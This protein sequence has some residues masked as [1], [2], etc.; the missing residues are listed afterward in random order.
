MEKTK[1]IAEL[2]ERVAGIE[3]LADEPDF[4]SSEETIVRYLK[5]RDW[6]VND[7]EKMLK[8]SIE[9][10]RK[11]K[12]LQQDCKWCHERPGCHS[13]RQVGFDEAGRPVVYS[14]FAQASLRHNSVEDT[15]C[16]CTFLIEN[17]KRT[18]KSGVSTWVFII[19]CTGMT[20]QACNPKLGYGVT[21]VMS[22]HYP[23]HLGLVIC[24]N[25]NPVFHGIWKAMKVFIHPNTTA[26][27][28]LIKSKSKVKETFQDLFPSELADWLL[29]EMRLNKIH[30]LPVTQKEF[31]NKPG[32][33]MTHDPR[34][35]PSYVTKYINTVKNGECCD[36]QHKPH[37]NIMDSVL[38]NLK[39]VKHP[40]TESSTHCS[41]S[42][43][44]DS[45]NSDT[46]DEFEQI[47][48]IDIP[49]EFKVPEG[50]IKFT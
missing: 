23:E 3:P 30:P 26:K 19:D 13:M 27:V 10:R 41:A 11:V 46:D 47:E 36:N 43:G 31:W 33:S 15:V 37:P 22:N 40:L 17:A 12:P 1:K 44:P 18:M 16:H 25:H 21:Q 14:N 7:A 39:S 38:G 29:E 49:E 50:A 42:C 2:R 24:V 45:G 32:K 48:M 34:G 5:S 8:E 4:F 6:N 28:K 35:C 9:Y 20:I